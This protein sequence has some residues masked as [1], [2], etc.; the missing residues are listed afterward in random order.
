MALHLL[1]NL[2]D[3]LFNLKS[4]LITFCKTL[5]KLAKILKILIPRKL[6]NG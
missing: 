1:I 5:N 4:F 6:E 2:I 3:N